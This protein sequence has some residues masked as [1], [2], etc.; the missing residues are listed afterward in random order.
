MTQAAHDEVAGRDGHTA[1]DAVPGAEETAPFDAMIAFQQGEGSATLADWWREAERASRASRSIATWAASSLLA[2][3]RHQAELA[4][5]FEAARDAATWLG[6]ALLDA[7]HRS[8]TLRDQLDTLFGDQRLDSPGPRPAHT[9]AQPEGIAESRVPRSLELVPQHGQRPDQMTDDGVTLGMA[10]VQDA[11]Q[12]EQDELSDQARGRGPAASQAADEE[13]PTEPLAAGPSSPPV[14]AITADTLA[15][16]QAALD[17]GRGTT[18]KGSH[19]R[20]DR[21]RG[22]SLA[23]LDVLRSTLGATPPALRDKNM[24]RN[25]RAQLVSVIDAGLA[26]EL[27]GTERQL[28]LQWIAARLRACG[29]VEHLDEGVSATVTVWMPKLGAQ[30]HAPSMRTPHCHGLAVQHAPRGKSW[31]AD[32]LVHQKEIDKLTGRAG[33]RAD[34]GERTSKEA[35][36]F[37]RLREASAKSDRPTLKV[38]AQDLLDLGVGYED[39][40]WRAPLEPHLVAFATATTAGLRRL[41]ICV[42]RQVAESDMSE[43]GNDVSQELQDWPWLEATRGKRLL[44][45]GGDG[46]QERIPEIEA[47]FAL[48][49]ATW[50]ALPKHAPR[51]LAASIDRIKG[52]RY[53]LVVCLQRFVS[54]DITDAV[55]D[56]DASCAT[57]V[58]ATSYGIGQLQRGF[59]RFLPQP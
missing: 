44:I 50:D 33:R 53:D 34:D 57:R 20:V 18:K 52:G 5:A 35:D 58:L 49:H 14:V 19:Q 22:P 37:R 2:T 13:L 7:A 55:W 24:V 31:T 23:A 17:N 40:R 12:D 25:E 21:D 29:D 30:L 6:L 42:G 28:A 1:S 47:A 11:A 27:V 41:Q 8:P 46:R 10:K 51:A 43:A 26:A 15:R 3:Q 9:G 59:E 54:H 32:A 36:L 48:A 45:L 38:L 16:L 39:P 56:L 4:R